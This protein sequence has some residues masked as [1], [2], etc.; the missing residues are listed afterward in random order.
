M[1]QG[2]GQDDKGRGGLI[3]SKRHEQLETVLAGLS[4]I[5]H[6]PGPGADDIDAGT[7]SSRRSGFARCRRSRI[8]RPAGIRENDTD[9]LWGANERQVYRVAASEASVLIEVCDELFD[10]Y[11]KPRHVAAPHPLLNRK[12]TCGIR[13]V[14]H[15]PIAREPAIQSSGYGFACTH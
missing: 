15:G 4:D 12:V 13:G 6:E 2:S 5:I 10:D 3:P 1:M 8:K 9:P 11:A 14:A 7:P